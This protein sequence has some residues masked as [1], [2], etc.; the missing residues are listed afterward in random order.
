MWLCSLSMLN[1][2]RATL[3][4]AGHQWHIIM[5]KKLM[6]SRDSWSFLPSCLSFFASIEYLLAE[7]V[8]LKPINSSMENDN[9]RYG[10][11]ASKNHPELLQAVIPHLRQAI[12]NHVLLSQVRTTIDRYHGI[13]H[14]FDPVRRQPLAARTNTHLTRVP[15][16]CDQH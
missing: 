3:H 1:R 16:P 2:K 13:T 12:R 7:S 14:Y 15:P 6:G 8:R 4:S 9:E 10:G 5:N 11:Y